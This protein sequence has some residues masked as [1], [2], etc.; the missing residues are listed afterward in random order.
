[1]SAYLAHSSPHRPAVPQ[2]AI[3]QTGVAKRYDDQA[4]GLPSHPAIHF[5]QGAEI[6]GEGDEATAF[7]KVVSGVVRI[8]KF[9]SDGRRQIE[10]FH[11]AGDLFGIE[12]GAEHC[13][14]AEAV[15]DCKVVAYHCRIVSN[16]PETD[17]ALSQQLF[18]C[19]LRN[20][21]RA[22]EH[23]VLLGRRSAME[24][25]GAFLLDWID[26][27]GDR[28]AVTL[29]MTRQDIAD[30]LGLTIETVSRTISQME[31]DGIIDI[32]SVRQ[33]AVKDP[34]ALEELCA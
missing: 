18:S 13:M 3:A 34:K 11:V 30:Y 25:V 10:A 28:R 2:A 15:T 27:S 4:A 32:P 29:A 31:R 14:S 7:Y 9:L 17:A 1:M 5:E 33:I 21:A 22:Q 19:A 16:L 8:C 26:R 23:S 24:K 6:Y 20:L 12:L